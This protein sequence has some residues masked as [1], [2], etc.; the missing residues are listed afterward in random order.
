[1]KAASSASRS[2][3]R[4]GVQGD[5]PPAGVWGRAPKPYAA[6]FFVSVASVR[7]TQETRLFPKPWVFQRSEESSSFFLCKNGVS[8]YNKVLRCMPFCVRAPIRQGVKCIDQ[9]LRRAKHSGAG[10]A[11]RK[12][13]GH[14]GKAAGKASRRAGCAGTKDHL[15]GLCQ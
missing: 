4:R 11:G 5:H 2:A 12:R 3:P 6:A 14:T 10:R 9:P 7:R 1:M 15:P 13:Q 8:C